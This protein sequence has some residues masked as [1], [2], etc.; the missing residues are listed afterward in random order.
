MCGMASLSETFGEEEIMS[1]FL[2][3]FGMYADMRAYLASLLGPT[4]VIVAGPKQ[5][6]AFIGFRE[7]SLERFAD[8]LIHNAIRFY[9]AF[10]GGVIIDGGARIDHIDAAFT[11]LADCIPAG[12]KLPM[13]VGGCVSGSLNVA[14]GRYGAVSYRFK[15]VYRGRGIELVGGRDCDSESSVS[16]KVRTMQEYL[17]AATDN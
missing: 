13:A 10:A 5:V 12:W 16:S 14:H 11:R 4:P 2:R 6:T 8:R 1:R 9:G 17:D 15:L 3:Y 7:V